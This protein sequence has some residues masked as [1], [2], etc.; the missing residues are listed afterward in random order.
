MPTYRLVIL[1]PP[2][3]ESEWATEPFTFH[4]VA[5]MT[6]RTPSIVANNMPGGGSWRYQQLT[7]EW[8][9]VVVPE[10]ALQPPW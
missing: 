9:D 7:D 5:T 1:N 8:R 3:S 2:G 10:P 6:A 4:A